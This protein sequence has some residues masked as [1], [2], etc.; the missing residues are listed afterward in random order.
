ML[1]VVLLTTGGVGGG[2]GDE[3]RHP[4]ALDT[5]GAGGLWHDYFCVGSEECRVAD[6][7][8]DGRADLVT[9]VRSTRTGTGAGDVYVAISN[10]IE[11]APNPGAKWHDWFCLGDEVCELGDVNGDGKADLVTFVRS[12]KTGAGA[13]DVYVALSNGRG[14]TPNPGA[15]WHDNFCLGQEMCAVGDVNGDGKADLVTFV[16][17]TKPGAAAGDVY[18]ALS[19]GR[20][21]GPNPGAKWH[22]W[23]CLG[24]EVCRL[25]DVNGDGKADLVTFVRSTRP[26]SAAGDVYVA[27]SNGHGFG[28]NPGAKW[29]D[30]FCLGDEI[31]QLAD[32]NGDGKA[33]L[34]AFVRSAKPGNAAGDVYVALSN[35]HGFA[36]NPGERWHD[37]FCLGQEVCQSGDVNG[38]GSADILAFARS[39]KEGGG[40]GD[41]YV[42]LAGGNPR[43]AEQEMPVAPRS[44]V[45]ADRFGWNRLGSAKGRRPLLVVVTAAVPGAP[46]TPLAHDTAYYRRVFF[47][48]NYPSIAGYY[49]AISHGLF[50]W[51]E[52]GV[53]AIPHRRAGE[54]LTSRY[55]SIKDDAAAAGFNFARFDTNHDGKVMP[56]ELG[57]VIVDNYSDMRGQTESRGIC[58]RPP[59]SPVEV[60]SNVSA[61]GHLSRFDN[62]AHELGHQLGLEDS[63]GVNCYLNDLGLMGSCTAGGRQDEF[64]T[65]HM[66][67]FNKM[68]LGWELPRI[69]DIGSGGACAVL[70]QADG[71][72]R[73]Q[74]PVLLFDPRRGTGEYL[75]LEYRKRSA[76]PGSVLDSARGPGGYDDH[77]VESGLGVW[78]LNTSDGV[79]LSRVRARIDPGVDGVRQSV[80]AAGS[81]DVPDGGRIWAGPDGVLQS[82]TRGDD[83]YSTDVLHYVSIDPLRSRPSRHLFHREDGLLQPRWFDRSPAGVWL[84]AGPAAPT[85]PSIEVEWGTGGPTTR[86]DRVAPAVVHSPGTLVLEGTLGV[87]STPRVVELVAGSTRY[88]M[89]VHSWTCGRA[90]V[91]VPAGIGP[92]E[93][94]LVV[95]STQT[96]GS[97][98]NV[99]RVVVE[100]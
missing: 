33:D 7:N 15:K 74:M 26:R 92:G 53:L 24:D 1:G 45:L 72:A 86:I 84:R 69:Y 85:S 79:V 27:L 87:A 73:S 59:G 21:F 16:R 31:C 81:D 2:P 22:D 43:V 12:T 4:A 88:R 11:F 17:S 63:Y 51:Q 37:W 44:T 20:A 67:P 62:F 96:G 52:A 38:D 90:V 8:G 5:F 13:G 41:V 39:T 71:R 29:H 77:V 10:G 68:I 32:V 82:V 89:G 94:Q 98:S 54:S 36:P 78:Y 60:C 28:P 30:W 34:V 55:Q 25:A 40:R 70:G 42:A 75:L 18:V 57:I 50:T 6:V 23:F 35:G 99:V 80:V 19:N 56:Y 95:T 100:P 65:Y 3:G 48:P 93:Y 46:V 76:T 91:G 58:H 9:F 14:F 66:S 64:R 97:R 83:A 61:V 47:G 49:T